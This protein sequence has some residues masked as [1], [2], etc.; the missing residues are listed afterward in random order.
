MNTRSMLKK[1]IMQPQ[2]FQDFLIS[3]K[4]SG[5]EVEEEAFK[6]LQGFWVESLWILLREREGNFI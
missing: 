3:L 1:K 2:T 4:I 5:D 6:V